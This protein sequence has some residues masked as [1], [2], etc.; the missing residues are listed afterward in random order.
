MESP[1]F[2]G[3]QSRGT[4]E[5]EKKLMDQRDKEAMELCILVMD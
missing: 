4:R 3:E 2:S 5:D 1:E